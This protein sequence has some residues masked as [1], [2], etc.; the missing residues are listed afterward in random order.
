MTLVRLQHPLAPIAPLL[1]DIVAPARAGADFGSSFRPVEADVLESESE[2][3]IV[4]DTPGLVRDD[5]E[6]TFEE[7][8]LNIT[9]DRK[10]LQTQEGDRWLSLER[11][12][13]RFSRSFRLPR[14]VEAERISAALDNGVLT[15]SVPKSERARR[16]RI[17]I[18]TGA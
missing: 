13:G 17:E 14:D 11:R 12:F 1:R 7:G 5:V 4:M 15:V 10:A 16:R 6:I 8:V 3:R 9:A 18:G 2:I